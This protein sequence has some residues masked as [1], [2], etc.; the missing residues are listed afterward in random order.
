MNNKKNFFNLRFFKNGQTAFE[1]ILLL[2]VVLSIVL[3]GFNKYLPRTH[4]AANVFFDKTYNGIV[5]NPPG[6]LN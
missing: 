4:S 2:A 6:T 3:I 1:Y 5:G